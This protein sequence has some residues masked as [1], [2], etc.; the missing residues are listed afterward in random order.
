MNLL[1]TDSLKP[2]MEKAA[3][4]FVSP[5]AF[6]LDDL[7]AIGHEV[8]EGWLP[9]ALSRLVG[10]RLEFRRFCREH[11]LAVP[12]FSEIRSFPELSQRV[13]K[14]GRFP[15]ALKARGNTGGGKT[16]FRLEGYR[17]L[18]RFWEKLQKHAPGPALLEPWVDAKALLEITLHEQGIIL[19]Q[20]GL[21]QSLTGRIAWRL[22]PVVIPPAWKESVEKV[23]GFF[24]G[25]LGTAQGFVRL[26]IALETSGITL[27]ALNAGGNRLEYFPGWGSEL[28][29]G[30]SLVAKCLGV[31][32]PNENKQTRKKFAR[33]GFFRRSGKAGSFPNRLPE[34]VKLD[35]FSR[36]EA[37]GRFAALLLSG[38]EPKKLSQEARTIATLLAS[39][40]DSD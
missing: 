31:P 39:S 18:T 13:M 12:D 9:P 14:L 34:S 30:G 25:L 4:S 20:A 35:L 37:C 26:T 10:D 1:G 2:L 33:L 27:L 40:E 36:Y 38:N 21:E 24:Q 8:P 11:S 29:D 15:L 17:E 22:F 16:T 3:L 6:P 28:L 7:S 32:T 19:S 23:I 5:R